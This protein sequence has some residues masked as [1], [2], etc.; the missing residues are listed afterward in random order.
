MKVES[1]SRQAEQLSAE[2]ESSRQAASE[3][4]RII[5]AEA[6]TSA[7][8]ILDQARA[9]ASLA[10]SEAAEQADSIRSSATAQV[11]ERIVNAK[12]EAESI[13]ESVRLRAEQDALVVLEE[14]ST[15]AE[16]IVQKALENSD[17]TA[18]VAIELVDQVMRDHDSRS[19]RRALEALRS[20]MMAAFSKERVSSG[21]AKTDEVLSQDTPGVSL[22]QWQSPKR[23]FRR[24]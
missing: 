18:N 24:S 22:D 4:V 17:R 21:A 6:N 3:Q 7:L 9:E 12:R 19:A 16:G 10:L 2:L 11:S 8:S 5:L 20:Q 14:A 15:K 23:R 1:L 13:I